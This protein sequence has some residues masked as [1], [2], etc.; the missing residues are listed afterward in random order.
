MP[1]AGAAEL[2]AAMPRWLPG[3]AM[4]LLGVVAI[5]A[6]GYLIQS[7]VDGDETAEVAATQSVI[8]PGADPAMARNRRR[9]S[10]CDECGIVE[11]MRVVPAL[12]GATDVFVART[13]PASGR[14][15]QLIG[16]VPKAH[17]KL[18][19]VIRLQDG[20]TRTITDVDTAKWKQGERVNVIAGLAP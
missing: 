8:A 17:R 6:S 9:T 20:S 19:I 14:A 16:G 13:A 11:S 15:T 1:P 12:E 4:L 18:E 7:L 10:R 3:A 2:H 5:A